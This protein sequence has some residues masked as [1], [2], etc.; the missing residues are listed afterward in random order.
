M[1]FK[2]YAVL[3]FACLVAASTSA[4][5]LRPFTAR[6]SNASERGNIVFVSNNIITS[7]GE[8]TSELP[9]GGLAANNGNTA[10]YIDADGDAATFMYYGSAWKYLDNNTR[11]ANWNTVAYSDAAWASGNGELGYGDGDETTVVSYGPDAANKYI[12]TYFRKT[13]NVTNPTSYSG[14]IMNIKRDDGVVV[15]I[16]GVEV[17]RSNMPGGAVAHGTLSS[18]NIDGVQEFVSVTLAN[19]VFVNGANTIAVEVHQSGPT[20]TDISF[21]MELKVSTTI[22]PYG[23]TWKYLSQATA[24]AATWATPGF[25]E[26]WASGP[27]SFYYNNNVGVTD[28]GFGGDQNLRHPTV[29]FRKQV[30]ITGLASYTSFTVNMKRDDGAAVYVN[31]TLVYSNNLP[32]TWTHTTLATTDGIENATETISFVI[33]ASSFVEGSNMIALG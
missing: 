22:V 26:T 21:D 15:Y 11:P 12:T 24:P 19:T 31:G 28:V 30:T 2:S 10:A 14:F 6:Y 29:Y 8:N 32:A 27:G 7:L 33:P 4:Q 20:S 23:S 1:K 25:V 13:I 5:I 18:A 16:N 17:H 9:P 3:L